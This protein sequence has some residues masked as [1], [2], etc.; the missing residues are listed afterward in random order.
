MTDFSKLTGLE[1][2]AHLEASGKPIAPIAEHFN[3]RLISYS[4]GDIVL[5]ATPDATHYN[6]IGT[7]HGGFA[8]TLLDSACG[9]AVHTTL[10]PG[11]AYTSLE[12][13]VN[14][15]RTITA[16]TGVVR[17]HGWVVKA[18]SRAAFAEADVRDADGRVL[19]TATSTCAIF[20]T[21]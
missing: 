1:Q 9:T 11:Q 17:V 20:A 19:A 5:E 13:K 18:G 16:D 12:I 6:P 15:L 4:D 7:V 10:R 8:A 2:I 21:C 14:Y 3:M